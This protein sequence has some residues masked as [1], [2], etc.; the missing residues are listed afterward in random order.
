MSEKSD[1]L[2]WVKK[3]KISDGSK[4]SAPITREQFWVMLYRSKDLDA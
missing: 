4:G 2:A 3:N 1:A